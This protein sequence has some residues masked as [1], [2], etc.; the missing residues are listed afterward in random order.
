MEGGQSGTITPLA[1]VRSR[2][3]L[4]LPALI[5]PDRSNRLSDG[6]TNGHTHEVVKEAVFDSRFWLPASF[7]LL[8]GLTALGPATA[9]AVG[10]G[11]HVRVHAQNIPQAVAREHNPHVGVEMRRR[12]ATESEHEKYSARYS[13]RKCGDQIAQMSDR[14]DSFRSTAAP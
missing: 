13:W 11:V 1:R 3:W 12:I 9:E 8:C 4:V 2:K 6:D 14:R 5:R 10:I 7:V